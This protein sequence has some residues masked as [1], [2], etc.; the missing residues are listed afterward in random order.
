[1]ANRHRLSAS[2]DSSTTSSSRYSALEQ[3]ANPPGLW[4]SP[5]PDSP[6]RRNDIGYARAQGNIPGPLQGFKDRDSCPPIEYL[7]RME[8][9]LKNAIRAH[10]HDIDADAI[11]LRKAVRYYVGL[12]ERQRLAMRE[13]VMES[14]RANDSAVR[15][16]FGSRNVSAERKVGEILKQLSISDLNEPLYRHVFALRRF[17]NVVKGLTDHFDTPLI[18]EETDSNPF[19]FLQINTVERLLTSIIATTLLDWLSVD[20]PRLSELLDENWESSLHH[21]LA[22]FKPILSDIHTFKFKTQ[23]I[24]MI[25]VLPTIKH[26]QYLSEVT[27]LSPTYFLSTPRAKSLAPQDRRRIEKEFIFPESLMEVISFVTHRH[28]SR[29]SPPLRI[30]PHW[31]QHEPELKEFVR[32]AEAAVHLA[33]AD[34]RRPPAT[35]MKLSNGSSA[36]AR[37]FKESLD[38]VT[39]LRRDKR[40][41]VR[42]W[43]NGVPNEEFLEYDAREEDRAG[44]E[45]ARTGRRTLFELRREEKGVLSSL[46]GMSGMG[47][48]RG[49]VSRMF[50]I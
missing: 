40:A 16:L 50:K 21:G 35:E 48:V 26:L 7:I 29:G 4:D 44:I 19:R 1:M 25:R 49:L 20:L 9:M 31:P 17:E 37:I 15:I 34:N 3:Y 23:L 5:P 13:L 38:R 46:G 33:T 30:P 14:C 28:L 11:S 10:V 45:W 36:G 39:R 22:G 43:A 12:V 32:A 42:Y 47:Q 27:P 18:V 2:P 41:W 24:L 8:V 6:G